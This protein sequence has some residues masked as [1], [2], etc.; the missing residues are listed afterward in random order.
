MMVKRMN[1][2]GVLVTAGGLCLAVGCATMSDRAPTP[3]T[4]GGR[5][6]CRLAN[7]TVELVVSPELGRVVRYGYVGGTNVLWENPRAVELAPK[8]AG[9]NNWGGDKVWPWPQAC[10]QEVAG[11]SWPPPGD[12]VFP[13][14]TVTPTTHGLRLVSAEIQGLGFRIVRDITLASTGSR[15]TFRNRLEATGPVPTNSWAVWTITQTAL[16]DA[17]LARLNRKAAQAI[18]TFAGHPPLPEPERH[19]R[20]LHFI[21]DPAGYGKSGF[22]A[23]LLAARFGDVLFT[24]AILPSTSPGSYRPGDKA[25]FYVDDPANPARP[26]DVPLYL[27]IELTSPRRPVDAEGPVLAVEWELR[28]LTPGERAPANLARLIESL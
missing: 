27:E 1:L 25:Q 2:P 17:M 13:P 16:P 20:V 10:W 23:D 21:G 7:D 8:V 26:P 11:C 15:V 12:G 22:D 24:Q 14:H 9:W 28:R 6:C 5:P 19:G 3:V 4:Y 18:Y